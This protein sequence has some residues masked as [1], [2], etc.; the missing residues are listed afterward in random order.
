LIQ[1]GL[2]L[3]FASAGPAL[4]DVPLLS[5]AVPAETVAVPQGTPVQAEATLDVNG[6]PAVYLQLPEPQATDFAR[7]TERSV[8]QVITISLCGQT[9]SA[10]RLLT[11]IPGGALVLA[12]EAVAEDSFATAAI[13]TSGS[14]D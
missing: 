1:R 12:G 10:P 5:L 7:L 6:S 4:A 11:P 13:L 14:C 9:V 8:G 3:L 2:L